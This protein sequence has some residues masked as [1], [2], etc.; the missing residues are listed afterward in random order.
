MP[1]EMMSFKLPASQVMQFKSWVYKQKSENVAQCRTLIVD[2]LGGIRRYAMVAA[3]VAKKSGGTLKQSIYTVIGHEELGGSVVVGRNYAAYQEF[4]TGRY[5]LKN[6]SQ[7]NRALQG[8]E[9]YAN[10]FRGKGLRKVNIY[11]HPYLFPA[12]SLGVRNMMLKL[13]RMGFEPKK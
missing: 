7:Y 8:L 11:P 5:A 6:Y 9:D 12:Y 3:P 13:K 4:G 10:E 2:T 1:K